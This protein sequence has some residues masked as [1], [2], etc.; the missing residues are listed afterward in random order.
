MT[1]YHVD[2]GSSVEF[3]MCILVV[4]AYPVVPL[5]E[6]PLGTDKRPVQLLYP[7]EIGEPEPPSENPRKTCE[8]EP[9]SNTDQTLDI[10]VSKKRPTRAAA[11]RAE[12]KSRVWIQELQD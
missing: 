3:R 1:L 12:E 5:C 11:K 10:L 7:L 9:H 6:L 8:S 2:S 4:M